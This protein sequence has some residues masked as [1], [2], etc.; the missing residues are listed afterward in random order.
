MYSGTLDFVPLNP[1]C[2]QSGVSLCKQNGQVSKIPA[3]WFILWF[4]IA[5]KPTSVGRD[6]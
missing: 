6:F 5:V 4:G 2:S 1:I 3:D